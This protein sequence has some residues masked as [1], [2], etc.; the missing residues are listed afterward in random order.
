MAEGRRLVWGCAVTQPDGAD[1]LAQLRQRIADGVQPLLMDTLPKPIAAMRAEEVAAAVLAVVQP[2]IERLRKAERAVN[3]LADA[4]RRA[5]EAEAHPPLHQWRVEILDGTEWM[6]AG[7]L[8]RDQA[9]AQGL[10]DAGNAGRPLWADGT[11][12]QRRLV[13]ETTTYTVE[14]AP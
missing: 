13:R 9:K 14:P 10:L 11:P 12:V 4:H 6:P 5:E 8:H 2:E 1:T 3:L 7:A